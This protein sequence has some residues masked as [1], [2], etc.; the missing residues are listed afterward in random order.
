[1]DSICVEDF[2]GSDGVGVTSFSCDYFPT[3]GLL[4]FTGDWNT[5]T[6]IPP[7][8]SVVVPTIRDAYT[9]AHAHGSQ[10]GMP[11]D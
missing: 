3:E 2:C 11:S 7:M 5:L 9:W 8:P 10:W 6:E 4:H 1:M